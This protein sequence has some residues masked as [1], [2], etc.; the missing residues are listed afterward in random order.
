MPKAEGGK[1]KKTITFLVVLMF[2]S[3]M[4]YAQLQID[5][6]Q[7]YGS[8]ATD[9]AYDIAQTDGGYLV[10]GSAYSGGGQVTCT[11]VGALW[12]LKIDNFGNLIW[13]KCYE[14]AGALRIVKAIGSPY[15]YLIG[16]A[17]GEP[18]PG[19][20]N[21]WIAKIDSLGSII[22]ERTLGNTIGILGGDQYGEATADGG[23]IATAQ[24]DSQGGDITTWH[25]W[26]DGWMIKLDSL[27]NTDWD[28]TIGSSTHIEYINGIIQTSD[29]G[30]LAGLYGTPQGAGTGNVDCTTQPTHLP[31]AIVFKMDSISNPE[32]HRC[33]GGSGS[34]GVTRLLEV[35]DGYIIA[36]WGGSN[37]GDLTGSGWHGNKDVWLVRTDFLGNII[38]QKCYGG[39][40]SDSP[41]KIFQTSDGGFMV[42]ANTNSFDGDVVGN[43]SSGNAS[44]IWIFKVNSIG[45]LLWQ[46]CIGGSRTE[47]VYGVIKQ[48]DCKYTVAGEMFYSPSGDVNCSNFVYGSQRNYWVFGISDTTVN[49][50]EDSAESFI[51][52]IYPNPAN[53]VL[54]ID[55]PN[56]CNIHN[57]IIKIVDINGRTMLK[58]EPVSISTQLDIKLL[59]N[60]LYLV[61]IQNDIS[62]TTK[63]IIIQ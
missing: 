23:V 37:D 26:Y 55:F 16:G 44:S 13:Q 43:P 20:Y 1:M 48:N 11:E 8:M 25:G 28:F 14:H 36:G 21:L 31:D 50:V 57:T 42:F 63:R 2:L 46:Q 47:Q 24:I 33:Y 54:N 29:N 58:S 53:S 18:Y 40:N 61:K 38:W 19:T 35:E 49:I 5:W 32:W 41:K 3:A 45:D 52:K 4:S 15:Y 60:G 39:S 34:D 56:I 27:G 22:W 30:Y 62:L 12:L 7:S 10:V 59:T 17:M 51:V 6:Q 9:I